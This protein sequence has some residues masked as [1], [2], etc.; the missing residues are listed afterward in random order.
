[1]RWTSEAVRAVA[2]PH[3]R[4]ILAALEEVVVLGQRQA[5]FPLVLTVALQAVLGENRLDLALEV[6]ARGGHRPALLARNRRNP[7]GYPDDKRRN[8]RL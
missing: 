7:T 2:R 3:D 5:A 1:M 8:Q 4:A 6:D